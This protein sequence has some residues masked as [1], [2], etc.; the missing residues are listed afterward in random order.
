M[1]SGIGNVY[2]AELLFRARQ[3]PHTPGRDVPEDVVRGLWKDWSKLL[4]KGVEVGQ[5]MTMDGLR[6]KRLDAALRNR[7][8]GT[9]STTARA[10]V[11]GVRHEH[12]D[13]GGRRPEAVLVPVLPGVTVAGPEPVLRLTCVAGVRA[14]AESVPPL[15]RCRG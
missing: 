10:A 7:A 8:T 4:R 3:N 6:G 5:M 2:R 13:G 1:V 12:R 14:A 11:P 15:S 9:G